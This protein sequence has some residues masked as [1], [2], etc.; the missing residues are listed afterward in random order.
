MGTRPLA[1]ELY[2]VAERGTVV[3]CYHLWYYFMGKIRR[4]GYVFITW[5][6]DHS[7]RH[8]HVYRDDR[9]VVKW[10][11]EKHVPIEGEASRR[12]RRLITKLE[13]EGRL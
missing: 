10:N 1:R 7:P 9:L 3:K 12:V 5:K 13:Q 6:G 4:G 8:V 2:S 11:L